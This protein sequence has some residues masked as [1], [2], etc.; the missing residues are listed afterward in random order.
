MQ[1]IFSAILAALLL[2]VPS[3]AEAQSKPYKVGLVSHVQ[4][5]PALDLLSQ[6]VAVFREELHRSGYVEGQNF[7]LLSRFTGDSGVRELLQSDVDILVAVWSPMALAAK[8]ATNRVPIVAV[9]PR[10]PVEQGLIQTL[11][12][13]GGNLTGV[14]SSVSGGFLGIKRLEILKELAP[15][16]SRV[17]YL[18]NLAFPGTQPFLVAIEAASSKL[19]LTVQSFDVR[20]EAD[21]SQAF[22]DMI[23]GGLGAVVVAAEIPVTP[24]AIA[25]A[26]KHRLPVVYVFRQAVEEGGLVAYDVDRLELFRRGA[27]FVD[28]I[29]KG[30]KPADLPFEQPT[31]FELVINLKTAKALGLIVPPSLLVRA[32]E[33]IQ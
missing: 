30:A 21:M 13:P 17:A 12:R 5:G 9:G 33:V 22:T 24:R 25:F 27:W 1:S 18:T 6:G 20:S 3:A 19:G 26:A 11:A 16:V 23:R 4:S 15:R 28:R 2:V 8:R 7:A 31:R 32:T 14:A 10:D 29:L